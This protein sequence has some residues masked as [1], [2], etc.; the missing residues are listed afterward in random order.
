MKSGDK[1]CGLHIHIAS[2][3]DGFNIK[4][5]SPTFIA[6]FLAQDFSHILHIF[7]VGTPCTVEAYFILQRFSIK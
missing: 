5:V 6:H 7:L 4:S 1:R 2:G 3:A